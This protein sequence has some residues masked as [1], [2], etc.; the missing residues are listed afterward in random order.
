MSR[1]AEHEHHRAH[2]RDQAERL[3]R[4]GQRVSL[5]R[6]VTFL[7]AAILGAAAASQGSAALG[8]A[9][10]ASAALFVGLV[11][12]HA[13]VLQ[14]AEGARVRADVHDRHLA[15]MDGRWTELP[16]RTEAP[17]PY[18]HPYAADVDLLGP[19][20]L[21]QRIDVTRTVPGE[22]HL[23]RWLGAHADAD[24]IAARQEAVRE[25]ATE[26][27]WRRELEAAAA[28]A[29]E[30]DKLDPEPF[31]AFVTRR[32]LTERIRPLVPLLYALPVVTVGF[33]VAATAGLL[34]W[35]IPVLL[36]VVQALVSF[37]SGRV[38]QDA[39]DLVSARRGYA[40]AFTRA[41]LQM[42]RAD[43]QAPLL[44][45]LQQ[46]LWVHGH[47]PSRYFRRLDRW[48]GFAELRHQFPLNIVANV[49][50]LWDLHVL[51][52]LET[53]AR[54]VG[55]GLEGAFDALGEMEALASLATFA[56]VDAD[57][58]F[59]EITAPD[60]PF[61]AEALQ[62]PLLP[63]DARVPNDVHL[64]G[65]GTALIV[66]GSNMA[67]KSTLLR[68]VGLNVAS[69][70]AG[71]PVT[72][73]AMRVPVVRLRAS[74]RVDDSLQRGASYFHAELTK[75]RLVVDDAEGH[76]PVMF[77]LDEML[78]GTNARARHIGARSVLLHL[79]DRGATG[80]VATHDVAL[81]ELERAHPGRIGNAHFTDVIHDGEMVFDYRL[82]E[83]VVQTSNALE[84]LRRAGV[85][86]HEP[87]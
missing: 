77:L 41:L 24:T 37:G 26:H 63:P 39:L 31:V 70:L 10:A 50:L 56:D 71:G 78:R 29:A 8:A 13:R 15:R 34:A 1:A 86:V 45:A 84:L 61:E 9:A 35:R 60:T 18:E 32:P 80:L 22:R 53:W 64:S 82:R 87:P 27:A 81:A 79:L 62:H 47:P 19:G 38:T 69:A 6:L 4:Q 16:N 28:E 7:L 73:R 59:P 83:G 20:S 46:R 3:S 12:W 5:G 30:G 25:L 49:M 17:P 55:E 54:E 11:V 65:P 74:M 57:A 21:W 36:L 43:L 14:R 85:E 66:T 40:E 48:A 67:G 68:A 33:V 76:P 44:R 42:E 23:R 52:R 58:T 75:L 72:A 51:L 2:F